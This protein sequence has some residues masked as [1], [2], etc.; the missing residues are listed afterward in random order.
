MCKP[1]CPEVDD[2]ASA[3]GCSVWIPSFRKTP[4]FTVTVLLTLALGIRMALGAERSRVI[5]MVMGGAT[6]QAVA[7]LAIR[8]CLA[9][10]PVPAERGRE[11]LLSAIHSKQPRFH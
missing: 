11:A 9:D 8:G 2:E 4:G 7:G 10:N 1:T 3:A 6:L 5:A